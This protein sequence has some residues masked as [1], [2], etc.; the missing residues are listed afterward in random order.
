MEQG[1]FKLFCL[2][3]SFEDVLFIRTFDDVLFIRTF[4]DVLFMRTF[5][6]V[7][8]QR[9]ISMLTPLCLHWI[10]L[11]IKKQE[12][13]KTKKPFKM[14]LLFSEVFSVNFYSLLVIIKQFAFC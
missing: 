6:D 7:F 4:E 3:E 14:Y 9:N 1:L 8:N 5:D 11:D 2:L 12:I 10:G 13:I